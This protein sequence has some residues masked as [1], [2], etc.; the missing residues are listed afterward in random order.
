MN[1]VAEYVILYDMRV[2]LESAGDGVWT[3]RKTGDDGRVLAEVPGA[4]AVNDLCRRLGKSRRQVYRYIK[5]G[6]L[7]PVGKYLGEWLVDA[8]G[9]EYL[10]EGRPRHPGTLP[11]AAR[12]LFPEYRL[13]DL[14]PIRD[15]AVII[16]RV[17]E[18]GGRDE[19]TWLFGQ[20]PHQSLEHWLAREGWR[21]TPRSATFWS[22]ILGV[23]A[24]RA[25]T[26]S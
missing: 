24:P 21:L 14:H 11:S 2:S 25:R 7:V 1:G 23:K 4:Y 26:V 20:Y 12:P 9:I 15:A 16:Q 8:R 10:L 6:W 22:M 13:E 19:V 3:V 17:L 5:D 18:M